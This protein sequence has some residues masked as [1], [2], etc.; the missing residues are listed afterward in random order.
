MKVVKV[1]VKA[2]RE[3]EVISGPFV[4]QRKKGDSWTVEENFVYSSDTPDGERS[5][6]L[7]DDQRLIIEGKASHQ[8]VYDAA[9]A[10]A[11]RRPLPETKKPASG[12]GDDDES[13]PI[14][15]AD[16]A[17]SGEQFSQLQQDERRDAAISAARQKLN[18]S[19][20]PTPAPPAPESEKPKVSLGDVPKGPK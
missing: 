12:T 19:K 8:V 4:V 6:T 3:G 2:A 17:M 16:Q 14:P 13:S 1:S 5:F 7:S 15:L 18:E 11:V 10:A 9:Q 20:N